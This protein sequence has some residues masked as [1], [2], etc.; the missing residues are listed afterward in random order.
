M[1]GHASRET[2]KKK[3]DNRGSESLGLKK[4][5]FNSKSDEARG[6]HAEDSMLLKGQSHNEHSPRSHRSPTF[7]PASGGALEK[8]KNRKM[9]QKLKMP[10]Q[11]SSNGSPPG[12]EI[13]VSPSTI[14]QQRL[15]QLKEQRP[16]ITQEEMN[17]MVLT[18]SELQQDL[19]RI[20][21]DVFI[22]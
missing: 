20:G 7:Q 10:T 8:L 18:W 11:L 4:D 13:R 6:Y 16:Q 2:D 17:L 19:E 3:R 1:G 21:N 5:R 14:R 15:T 12:A 22:R 9:L